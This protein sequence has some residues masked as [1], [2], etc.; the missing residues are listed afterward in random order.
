MEHNLTQDALAE[1]QFIL[2]W[3]KDENE[4][5]TEIMRKYYI[6]MLIDASVTLARLW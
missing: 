3:F 4:M 6:H 5:M 1:I 2:F